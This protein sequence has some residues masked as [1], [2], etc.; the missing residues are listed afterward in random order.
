MDCGSISGPGTSATYHGEDGFPILEQLQV[1]V[2]AL[3]QPQTLEHCEVTRQA[4]R[5]CR[6]SDM[7]GDREGE[8]EARQVDGGDGSGQVNSPRLWCTQRPRS[9]RQAGYGGLRALYSYSARWVVN[10]RLC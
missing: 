3:P 2:V 5:E 7:R 8:L 1:S 4:D 6:E 10:T 9:K